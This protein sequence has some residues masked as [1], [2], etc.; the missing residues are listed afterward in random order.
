MEMQDKSIN[1]I[2]KKVVGKPDMVYDK[3]KEI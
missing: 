3:I 1:M 2:S